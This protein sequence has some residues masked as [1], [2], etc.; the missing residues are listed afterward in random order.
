MPISEPFSKQR[1]VERAK[2][3]SMF[4][5]EYYTLLY[6]SSSLFSENACVLLFMGTRSCK[7]TVLETAVF[8]P[9]KM[10][11]ASGRMYNTHKGAILC[12]IWVDIGCLW[13]PGTNSGGEP[14][15]RLVVVYVSCYPVVNLYVF[16]G[17]KGIL[18]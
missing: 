18:V 15:S 16:K 12:T 4:T 17:C 6:V 11:W 5:I 14:G 13:T 10:N 2:T 7:T 1:P 8:A 9:T 3:S